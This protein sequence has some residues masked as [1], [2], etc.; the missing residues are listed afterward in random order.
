MK[1]SLILL[2]IS[3]SLYGPVNA[4]EKLSPATPNYGSA[5]FA[6]SAEHPIGWRANGNGYYPGANPPVEFWD[7]T[8]IENVDRSNP[9]NPITTWDVAEDGKSKNVLWKVPLPGWSLAHPIVV[10]DRVYVVGEPDFVTCYDLKTGR[11]LWERRMYPLMMDGMPE[12]KAKEYQ[13]ALDLARALCYTTSAYCKSARASLSPSN[14]EEGKNVLKLEGEKKKEFL[15]RKRTTAKRLIAML[16]KYRPQVVALEDADILKGL[17]ADQEGLRKYAAESDDELIKNHFS[18]GN[19]TAE[20]LSL[21]KAIEKKFNVGMQIIWWGYVGVADSTL[22]SDGE[23]LYGVFGQGQVFCLDLDGKLVWSYRQ[24]GNPTQLFHRSPRICGNVVLVRTLAYPRTEKDPGGCHIQGVD[25]LTGK[26]LWEEPNQFAHQMETVLELKSP[27]GKR[28]P[29]FIPGSCGQPIPIRRVS[30]GKT[31]GAVP[32]LPNPKAGGPLHSKAIAPDALILNFYDSFGANG[33]S[34][35]YRFRLTS[36]DTVVAE[37]LYQVLDPKY[38]DKGPIGTDEM[39]L[40]T[41]QWFLRCP[42][43]YATKDGT[44]ICN[45]NI[46]GSR[47]GGAIGA[48]SKIILNL[49]SDGNVENGRVRPDRKALGRY[50]VVDAGDPTIPRVLSDRNFLGYRDPPADVILRDY[51]SEFDPLGFA[52]CYAGAMAHFSAEMGGPIPC[53]ERLL[54]QSTAYLYCLGHAVNGTVADDP[55]VV[56]TI[57]GAKS[58]E[59]VAKYLNS[60][61]AQYRYEALSRVITISDHKSQMTDKLT[62]TLTTLAKDDPYEEI[63]A[64]AILALDAADPQTRPGTKLILDAVTAI[65]GEQRSWP[66]ARGG[67][68]GPQYMKLVLTFR[69]LGTAGTA[70]IEQSITG[71]EGKLLN[72]LWVMATEL[73]YSSPRVLDRAVALKD[74]YLKQPRGWPWTWEWYLC[75][76]AGKDARIWPILKESSLRTQQGWTVIPVVIKEC[77]E[78]ERVTFAVKLFNIFG[79]QGN[80]HPLF[81]D[82]FVNKLGTKSIPELE[83]LAGTY[84]ATDLRAVSIKKW[85]EA[86]KQPSDKKP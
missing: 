6:P 16:D 82:V 31:L 46:G 28:V 68:M 8:V 34:V 71:A 60:P 7:G 56:A 13:V 47:G 72:G 78:G 55:K 19:P 85:V 57:R 66:E 32:F 12:G 18:N 65:L 70:I 4:G 74:I 17:D 50:A 63:R 26:I 54:L 33:P 3:A 44:I 27:D 5:D 77:P 84:S 86:I 15:E 21:V 24:R 35:A 43:L 76:F 42:C 67:A 30:D 58:V 29:V 20:F 25:K 79:G 1:F 83:K 40:T 45:A 38:K 80:I 48:G 81:E 59:S 51:L 23:R 53:G 75:K 39:I 37:P 2:L 69:A 61:G 52:A 22:A 64:S 73:D 14:S 10:K 9:R 41:D 36:S 49:G 62:G 11:K